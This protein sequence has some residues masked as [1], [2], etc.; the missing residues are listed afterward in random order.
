MSKPD[1]RRGLLLVSLQI[2]A[3]LCATASEAYRGPQS[4]R[5]GIEARTANAG[6]DSQPENNSQESGYGERQ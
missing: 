4:S 5:D 1:Q 2:C 6:G 3:I